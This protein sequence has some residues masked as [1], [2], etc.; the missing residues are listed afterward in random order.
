MMRRIGF[1]VINSIMLGSI[2]LIAIFIVP[3]V[4]LAN[5]TEYGDYFRSPVWKMLWPDLLVGTKRHK[6]R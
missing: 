5:Q 3:L 2:F 1:F 4:V 6:K